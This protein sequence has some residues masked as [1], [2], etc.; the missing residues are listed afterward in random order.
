MSYILF[1]CLFSV[2]LCLYSY[3]RIP[4]LYLRIPETGNTQFLT[5]KYLKHL[6]TEDIIPLQ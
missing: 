1:C 5:I 4:S 6:V 3:R 2:E